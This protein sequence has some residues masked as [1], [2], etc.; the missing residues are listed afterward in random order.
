MLFSFYSGFSRTDLILKKDEYINE[1]DLVHIYSAI[2]FL[3]ELKPIQYILG[4]TEFCGNPFKVNENVL[5]PR[6]ETEELVNLV[7]NDNLKRAGLHILDIGTGSGCIAVSLAKSLDN[8]VVTGIDISEKALDLAAE[9]AGL[10]HATVNLILNDILAI[11]DNATELVKIFGTAD[12]IVSNPPYI[13]VSEKESMNRN[14][15]DYEP[16]TALFVPDGNPLI[17]YERIVDSALKYSKPGTL[18]YFEINEN[19]REKLS[20][21]VEEKGILKYQFYKDIHGKYRMMK[22]CL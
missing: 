18:L 16:Q 15:V 7:V 17:F 20:G 22:V 21:M 8:A 6:P 12:I 19:Y 2:P 9:N 1:S 10:N 3:A 11:D 5:I 13:P 14:V 4:E